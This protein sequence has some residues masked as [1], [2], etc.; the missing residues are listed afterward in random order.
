M[1]FSIHDDLGHIK[2]EFVTTW[3]EATVLLILDLH[4]QVRRELWGDIIREWV[5][6]TSMGQPGMVRWES[7]FNLGHWIEWS[8][9]EV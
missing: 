7:Y 4:D 3:S 6:K 8:L 1:R 2:E 5:E 9:E